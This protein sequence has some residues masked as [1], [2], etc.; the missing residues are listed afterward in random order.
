MRALFFRLILL[1]SCLNYMTLVNYCTHGRHYQLHVYWMRLILKTRPSIW[2]ILCQHFTKDSS[3]IICFWCFCFAL[4]LFCFVLFLFFF[5]L[6]LVDLLPLYSVFKNNLNYY[7]L[8]NARDQYFP[9][10]WP[11]SSYKSTIRF[12]NLCGSYI[13]QWWT[14][15]I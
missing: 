9:H 8:R 14:P 3:L 15:Q 11:I 12:V 10:I 5:L 1:L 13:S 4:L 2:T 7:F 6:F